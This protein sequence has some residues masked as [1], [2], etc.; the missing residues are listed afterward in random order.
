MNV[1][2]LSTI[3]VVSIGMIVIVGWIFNIEV[4]KCVHTGFVPMMFNSALCL[5]LSGLSLRL[6]QTRWK[7]GLTSSL[8]CICSSLVIFIGFLT[9]CEYL[10]GLDL[11]ID[12]IIYKQTSIE[13]WSYIPGRMSPISALNFLL[14]G[15]A[16]L[17]L[18]KR[19][20]SFH[21]IV[22]L[23]IIIQ[24]SISLLALI[25]YMYSIS[26][27]FQIGSYKPIA[28]HT[29][30][31]F[32]LVF[33]AIFFAHPDRGLTSIY[34]SDSYA[35]LMLRR[36]LIFVVL[37]P[38]LLGAVIAL[39]YRIGLYDVFFSFLLFVVLTIVL[40]SGLLWLNSYTL[41]KTELK[42]KKLQDQLRQAQKMEAVG[43]LAGGIAHDFNNLLTVIRGYSDLLL[44]T[45]KPDDPARAE[46]Q[47][48]KAAGDRAAGL[49][50]QL[51]AFSRKQILQPKVL[52]LN[53]LV[54][55]IKKMLHSLIGEDIELTAILSESG[56]KIKADPG[57]I[58]Q[59]IMNLAVNARDAMPNGG[60]LTIGTST[61]FFNE[62][63]P[64]D[65]L[66]INPG[67]YVLLSV[68]DA[69]TGMDQETQSHIFEPFFTTRE[70]GTGLGLSTVYGIV[71]QSKGYIFVY[72]EPGK[73]TTFKIYLPLMDREET[74]EIGREAVPVESFRGC[75]TILLVEDEDLVRNFAKAVLK[76]NGY[77]V[78]NAK[79]G[80]EAL[81]ICEEYNGRIHCML[82]DVIMPQMSG[83]EL[84]ERLT[85]RYPAMRVVF[86]SG[87][88]ENSIVHHG[89]L[90]KG[91]NF[92]PKP[93]DAEALLKI[94]R[95]L[96]DRPE[97]TDI[98]GL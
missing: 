14:V 21:D 4:F 65:H 93:F 60:K 23:L 47:Q 85:K 58:E 19:T 26:P 6:I 51:L 15:A 75:E 78:L 56:V 27:L 52:A 43:R 74:E 62:E 98:D 68:D 89:G 40:F 90:D 42:R 2:K 37:V 72:S 36:L 1:S 55:N 34:I 49:T 24:G 12:Q 92:L 91:V 32:I 57:Q 28:I 76:K 11:R 53:D 81:K 61:V 39:G 82:T 97:N 13:D 50:E 30:T 96:L 5:V 18:N 20:R 69:G 22:Q 70:N 44:E 10:G 87:Y 7:H 38:I 25:G 48:I 3:A 86:V 94:I 71:K 77:T 83:K 67:H 73:G 46:I 80:K 45:L 41:S 16:L 88:D 17:M 84:A 79:G 95:E 63:Y 29:T 8:A 31:A 59:V 9:L 66:R 54:K 33:L 64:Q 35:G